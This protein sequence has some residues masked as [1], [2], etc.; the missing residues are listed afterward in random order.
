MKLS[1]KFPTLGIVALG[2]CAGAMAQLDLH[3]QWRIAA[4]S[5]QANLN[6]ALDYVNKYQTFSVNYRE[7]KSAYDQ[8]P[9][10]RFGPI[11]TGYTISLPN[12]NGTLSRFRV[13]ENPIMSPDLA[14]Q[15]PSRTYRVQGIDDPYAV[16]VLDTGANGFHGFIRSPKGDYIIDPVNLGEKNLYVSYYRSDN[17]RPRG[18]FTCFVDTT[19]AFTPAR[20]TVRSFMPGGTFKTYRLA[21]NATTEYTAFYGTV[22]NAQAG[23]V[24]SVNRVNQVYQIDM[25][26]T[27]TLVRNNP[28]TGA[29]PFTNS[30][31]VTMLGEN[32]TVCDATPGNAGYDI[33]HVFSTG[34]G[35]VAGLAV[36]G[37][38]GQKARGVTGSPSPIGDAFDIDY[39][40]HEMGHQFGGRHTFN[41]TTGNCGG[42]NRS[43]SAA[44]EPG[45]GSTVMA[46]AGICGAEDLQ[47]NSNAYFHARSFEEIWSWRDNAG[48]GGTSVNNGNIPPTASAGADFTIPINTPFKLTATGSD[49]QGDPITYCWEQFDLGSATSGP[50]QYST[51]PI[52]RSF[53]PVVSPTRFFPNFPNVRDNVLNNFDKLP[54]ANRTMTFRVTVRDNRGGGGAYAVDDTTITASGAAFTVNS[55]NTNVTLAGGSSQT[56][57]WT[58]GGG[59]VAPNVRILLS[60]DGGNSYANGTATVILASTP[61]DGSQTVTIP[62]IATTQARIII[63]AV[64][65]VFYDLS[66][67]NFTITNTN[68]P[69][70][71][72]TTITPNSALR[73]SGG[74]NMTVNGTN[75]V[76][77]SVVRLNGTIVGTT[78]F[79]SSTQLTAAI[80]AGSVSG[81]AGTTPVT[82]FNPTPGGGTSNAVNFTVNNPVPTLTVISP[83]TVTA[84]GATFN[85]TVTGTNFFTDSVVR[86]NGSA[87]TTTYNSPTQLTASI[88]AADIASVGSAAIT[89]FNASPG[90]GSSGGLNLTIAP[91]SVS[92]SSFSWITGVSTSGVLSNLLNSDDLYCAGAPDY[93][94]N[95]NAPNIQLEA[96]GNPGRNSASQVV[97]SVE[98]GA[99]TSCTM[100]IQVF[101]YSTSGWDTVDTVLNPITDTVRNV[102]LTTGASN[103]LSGGPLRVR[104]RTFADPTGP[105]VWT[106][107]VDRIA[108]TVNP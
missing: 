12:P 57:T 60:T 103:Y 66:N 16:G 73:G 5:A 45:S 80:P 67:V 46:Y 1:L 32:Q 99:T 98:L 8:V 9:V 72:I 10:Q 24:T 2:L 105:R 50:T 23:V 55:P 64:G 86:F 76:P 68:N 3:T 79:V 4:P 41:G 58:V 74:F 26:L 54:I 51:G 28:Y 20:E 37:V 70:P 59:S 43:A 83:G 42:G 102:T 11:T 29:D 27:M 48:S 30:N 31:G 39:V 71:T 93:T 36:V 34:G 77:S 100:D 95:R 44:Y 19:R 17:Q 63:E 56:I 101:N 25:A 108:W 7:L 97:V 47:P 49:S 6:P 21:M 13:A 84:G 14:I 96:S 35:G 15:V 107:R 78:T 89:V 61:N 40:A 85:L 33:G 38:A 65:N 91:I 92:P 69:V 75:F 104:V 18:E 94:V 62:N 53:S 88:T 90:G 106:S 52:F 22:T 87:R 82:V 81:P